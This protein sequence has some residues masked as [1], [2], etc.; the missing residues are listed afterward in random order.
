MITSTGVAMPKQFG[1]MRSNGAQSIR[2]PFSWAGEQPYAR[3]ADVPSNQ[4]ANFV[5][6]ARGVP[7]DFTSTDR[8]VAVAAANG[9]TVLPTVIYTPTWDAGVSVSNDLITPRSDGPY[10]DFLTTL[11]DRYGPSGTFW[12]ENPRLRRRPIR[13]WEVWNEP[14]L[15]FYWPIQPFEQSYVALLR[16]AH[17]AIKRADPRAQLVLAGMP[18]ASWSVLRSI[19]WVHGARQLFD[20]VDVHVYTKY[21]A[22]EIQILRLDR[23][24][25]DQQ[26]DGRKPMIVGETGWTSSLH[27]TQHVFDWDLTPAGQARSVRRL[28]PLLA[29]D[30]LRLRLIGLYWYTWMGD[31]YPGAS[32]WNFSGL[33]ALH[34]GQ[35]SAKPA[36]HAFGQTA[37]AIER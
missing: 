20:V 15:S 2:V 34:N 17:A 11:V 28:L 22:G 37:H 6:G 19:Y 18:N 27:Q 35:V 21:P 12:R 24:V 1:L 16:T 3:W 7:T 36:L 10:G 5:S 23:S 26:G 4:L 13:M 9:M 14:W 32:P 29:G 8:I 25:M 31:E 30:R 33:V